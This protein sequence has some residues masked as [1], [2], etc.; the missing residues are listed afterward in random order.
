MWKPL[1]KKNTQNDPNVNG[2]IN[3]IVYDIGGTNPILGATFVTLSTDP[4]LTNER[5]LTAGSAMALTD[6]GPG[7]S[8]VFNLADTAVTPGT[9]PLATVT[10]DQKGSLTAVSSGSA[11]A[12]QTTLYNETGS[13]A[14]FIFIGAKL[15]ADAA[16]RFSATVSGDLAW[17]DGTA[18]GV[19]LNYAGGSVLQIVDASNDPADLTLS[20]L[21]GNAAI[22]STPNTFNI[23]F[24]TRTAGDANPRFQVVGEGKIGLG[25]GSSG[26]D[27]YLWRSANAE[28]SLGSSPTTADG[29]LRATA[30]KTASGDLTLQP[31]GSNIN[32]SNKVVNNVSQLNLTAS[33]TTIA[34]GVTNGTMEITDGGFNPGT[35]K[36]SN[37]L[38]TT[39]NLY[40]N[41]AGS[42]VDFPGKEIINAILPSS[43]LS[44]PISYLTPSASN[45]FLTTKLASDTNPRF[46]LD[47]SGTQVWGPG[48]SGFAQDTWL[49]RGINAGTINI[50]NNSSTENGGTLAVSQIRGG[51]TGLSITGGYGNPIDFVSNNLTSIGNVQ[52][53]TISTASGNLVITPAG[54]ATEFGGKNI[55][56]I[57]TAT[58]NTLASPS[59]T[60]LALATGGSKITFNKVLNSTSVLA[61]TD[62]AFQVR[63]TGA[64]NDR[65]VI[66]GDGQIG[67]GYGTQ[68]INAFLR[69]NSV[70]SFTMT[71]TSGSS[72]PGISNLKVGSVNTNGIAALVGEPGLS[73]NPGGAGP[74]YQ[75]TNTC[76][77]VQ[78]HSTTAITSLLSFPAEVE[79]LQEDRE[80]LS[81]RQPAQ[82]SELLAQTAYSRA[83]LQE[84]FGCPR[85]LLTISDSRWLPRV[86]DGS[87]F[88]TQKR[89]QFMANSLIAVMLR[90][91]E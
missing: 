40:L 45:I 46:T 11:P 32:M 29:T 6:N 23:S 77:V 59:S 87:P 49:R 7:N 12:T 75:N 31:S 21:R 58:V 61:T 85:T 83:A 62:A 18:V 25:G 86:V 48:G 51:S 71:D 33:G 43:V 38:T 9:Y 27:T 17:G 70:S 89:R 24:E 2:T 67:L 56:S 44:F 39:G 63:P 3:Q 52:T 5:V 41:P 16:R 68:A 26:M 76:W 78:R 14:N 73:V 72:D 37:I 90:R 13:N 34:R 19:R 60:D 28:L 30:I 42:A 8:I 79:L 57:A 50:S 69:C 35:L 1:R 88:R 74:V 53:A 20:T 10:V 81:S 55:T 22:F 4:N 65:V 36:V 47:C 91:G 82:P 15:L 54:T 84:A 64:A 80:T 66:R